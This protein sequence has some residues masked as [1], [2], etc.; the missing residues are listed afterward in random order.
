MPTPEEARTLW[1][2][3]HFKP[4]INSMSIIQTIREKG[5]RITVVIIA[6]ALVGFILTDYFQS[7]NRSAGGPSESIGSVNG[8]KISFADF[9]QK[10]DQAQENMKQQGYPSSA[11]STQMA[12]DN[13][14]DQE[15]NRILMEE[16]FDRLGIQV[17]KK[18]LGDI[19]YGPNAPADLKSQFTD[20]KTGQYNAV[21][22]KQQVDQILKKGTPEQKASFNNYINQL[23]FQ[24]RYD[25]YMSLFTN[26]TNVPRWFVEKNNADESQ[27]AKASFVKEVY[28]AIPDSTI[29]IED[30]EIA[31]YISKHKDDFKQ[32]E[33]RSISYVTFSAAPSAADSADAR[34]QLLDMKANFD[35]TEN[36]ESLLASEGVDP[37]YNYNGYMGIGAIRSSYKDSIIKIP[38]GSVYGPYLDGNSYVLAKLEGVRGM[39]DSA[40][41]RHILIAT[42]QRDPQSGQYYP[43]RDTATA[44][45]LADSIRTAIAKGSVFDSLCVKF[46]D[47]PGSKDKGG[48]YDN[49]ASGRMVGSFN[50]FCFLNSVGSK[51]IVKTE[52]GYHYIEILSQKGNSTGYKIT[53]LP[54]EIVVSP[55]TE[56]NASNQANMFAGDSRDIKSFDANFEKNLKP[57][58][59]NKGLATVTPKD[60]QIM[61]VGYSRNFIR[62][63]FEGRAG[64][65]LK[66][67]KV[68]N[69]YVVAVITE[70]LKEG[71]MSVAKARPGVEAVLRNKKKA[72]MLKQKAGKITTLEAAAAAWGGKQIETIDSLRMVGGSS[73]ALGYEPRVTGAIFNPAN[74]GKV[75]PEALEGQS[76]VYVVRVDNITSTAVTTGS[77][78]DRRKSMADTRKG[79]Y[80]PIDALKKIATIKDKRI[81]RY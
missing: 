33:S 35:S 74:K 11:A 31:D 64:Q 66:P 19:L 79:T 63:I 43:I 53:M 17:S 38:V 8:R 1:L 60:A 26:S 78:A 16:E 40:K 58:G 81:E 4:Y 22:A 20:P 28:S 44:Y 62:S 56:N 67:E 61:G 14:W 80:N 32:N 29:K 3:G 69:N 2:A 45:K 65:V 7:R 23:I 18:E 72:E 25:K 50:D 51:G 49:F 54:R 42:T 30:K 39:P 59:L 70:V 27:M 36:T 76:G 46:S 73:N 5:A 6:I 12:I 9:N 77:V 15:V 52:F 41:V 10:V 57:K 71:T 47:D 37:A 48:V 55:E 34:R 13:T 24:R 75:V 21:Q 68:D